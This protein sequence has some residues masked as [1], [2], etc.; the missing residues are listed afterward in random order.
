MDRCL[1]VQQRADGAGRHLLP[2]VVHGHHPSSGD[3]PQPLREAG[4][5]LYLETPISDEQLVGACRGLLDA[6]SPEPPPSDTMLNG[7][8]VSDALNRLEAIIDTAEDEPTVVFQRELSDL[9]RGFPKQQFMP[10][11]YGF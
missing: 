4:C 7:A 8:E 1:W 9:G 3:L 2:I 11:G 6:S 10:F 5:R